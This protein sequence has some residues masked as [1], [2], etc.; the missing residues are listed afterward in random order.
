MVR[1]DHCLKEKFK[2]AKFTFG[3]KCPY[4]KDTEK[5][6]ITR[7]LWM[8]LIPWAKYFQCNWCACRFFS[9]LNVITF[10]IVWWLLEFTE[11][12]I[13]PFFVKLPSQH[14]YHLTNNTKTFNEILSILMFDIISMIFLGLVLI[15]IATIVKKIVK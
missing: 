3:V 6:R 14:N 9:I 8:R 11:I 4:C 12:H 5:I 15:V 13:Q 10:R 7:R 1:R 2:M